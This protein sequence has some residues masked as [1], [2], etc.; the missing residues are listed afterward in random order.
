MQ[1]T[2][3]V[4]ERLTISSSIEVDVGIMC[5]CMPL[6]P[7]LVKTWPSTEHLST[8]ISSIRS[9]LVKSPGRNDGTWPQSNF[10]LEDGR[11]A[12]PNSDHIAEIREALHQNIIKVRQ[13]RVFTAPERPPRPL[14]G[15]PQSC[16]RVPFSPVIEEPGDGGDT[17]GVH[18]S[19]GEDTKGVHRSIEIF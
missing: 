4:V 2:S 13:P 17:K 1:P 16:L 7:A 3:C 19:D 14:V 8:S 12:S 11:V 6:L 5:A 9:R 15:L 18:R 10:N